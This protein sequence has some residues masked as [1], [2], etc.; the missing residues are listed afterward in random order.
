MNAGSNEMYCGDC[1]DILPM[2][3]A[4]SADTVLADPPC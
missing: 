1:L 3:P 4:D 2:L